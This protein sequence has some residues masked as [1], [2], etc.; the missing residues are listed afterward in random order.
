MSKLTDRIWKRS[1]V[2]PK[3]DHPED[4]QTMRNGIADAKKHA[5]QFCKERETDMVRLIACYPDQ[6]A[7]EILAALREE[8]W[9]TDWSEQ[10]TQPRSPA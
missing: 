5:A 1:L 2:V 3:G 9:S 7:E 4:Q 10:H 6:D 8:F